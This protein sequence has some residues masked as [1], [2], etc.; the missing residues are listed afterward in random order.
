[1]TPLAAAESAA[2][3]PLLVVILLA[4]AVPLLLSRFPRVP[5]VVG[6]IAA[7][8]CSWAVPVS[9]GWTAAARSSPS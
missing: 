7:G 6:E 5:V 3:V 9:A 2:Y 8:A 4:F 1:M